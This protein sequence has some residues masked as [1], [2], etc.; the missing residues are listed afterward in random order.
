[1]P[2]PLVVTTNIENFIAQIYARNGATES[3][4][5]SFWRRF[6]R[7]SR[8]WTRSCRWI[9]TDLEAG[10][11]NTRRRRT[12]HFRRPEATALRPTTSGLSRP[13][14]CFRSGRI[15]RGVRVSGESR[16]RRRRRRR[17][18]R[19]RLTGRLLGS[20]RWPPERATSTRYPRVSI[21]WT[22]LSR[23]PINNNY[24]QSKYL[25]PKDQLISGRK[26]FA[27]SKRNSIDRTVV[28]ALSPK[29]HNLW[30]KFELW[31]LL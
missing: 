6:S 5:S 21:R 9:L 17:C 3:H 4:P 24:R 23:Y 31:G 26:T 22:V 8:S 18:H 10:C 27:I 29:S 13:P 30:G 14:R 2:R 16:F 12:S 20:P 19:R 15:C 11:R 7:P 1:M 28:I 25:T